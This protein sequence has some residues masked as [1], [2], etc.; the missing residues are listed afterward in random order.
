MNGILQGTTPHLEITIPDTCPLSAVNA[1][2][3][4]IKHK[5]QVTKYGMSDVTV[6]TTNNKITYVFSE[7]QTLALD[8][9]APVIWQLRLKTSGGILGTAEQEIRVYDLISEDVMA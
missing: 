3:L 1:I 6:D 5:D 4:T 2:E 9:K 8:P 7:T